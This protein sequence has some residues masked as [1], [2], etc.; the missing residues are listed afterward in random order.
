MHNEEA[1]IEE[2]LLRVQDAL[3]PEYQREAVV[4]LKELLAD[5][6]KVRAAAASPG[7]GLV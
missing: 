1:E 6:P 5:N 2:L 7:Q 4:Q 3:L